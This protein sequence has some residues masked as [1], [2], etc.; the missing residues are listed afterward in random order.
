[1]LTFCAVLFLV[2]GVMTFFD[3]ERLLDA[4]SSRK[5]LPTCAIVTEVR[6]K[7]HLL[8]SVSQYHGSSVSSVESRQYYYRYEVDGVT[9]ESTRFS[10]DAESRNNMPYWEVGDEITIYYDPANPRRATIRRGL[11]MMS[12]WIPLAAL[13]ALIYVLGGVFANQAR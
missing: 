6:D 5:W 10:F 9:H 3:R 13:G 11:T 12:L 2:F 1:M 4:W 7:T 8:D